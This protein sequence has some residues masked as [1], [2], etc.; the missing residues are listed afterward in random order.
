MSAIKATKNIIYIKIKNKH[1]L[2]CCYSHSFVDLLNN[3]RRAATTAA[4]AAMSFPSQT[5]GAMLLWKSEIFSTEKIHCFEYMRNSKCISTQSKMLLWRTNI[6]SVSRSVGLFSPTVV[7]SSVYGMPYH[8]LAVRLCI[9]CSKSSRQKTMYS[10]TFKNRL[11]R[12]GRESD[13]QE[14]KYLY[15][16]QKNIKKRLE[17]QANEQSTENIQAKIIQKEKN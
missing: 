4:A 17:R 10:R 12:V 15:T 3:M 8:K 14:E 11:Q 6:L 16:I 13:K 9:V 5:S 7:F 1:S 2:G